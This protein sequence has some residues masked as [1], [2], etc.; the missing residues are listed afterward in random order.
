MVALY[1]PVTVS[2]VDTIAKWLLSKDSMTPKKLQKMLY[3]CYSWTLA[4]LNEN[5]DNIEVRL[6]EEKFEAWVHGPVVRNVYYK[7]RENGYN[8]IP[9]IDEEVIIDNPE[10]LDILEQ[11]YDVY[12]GYNGNELE[13]ISHQETP[14]INAREGLQPYE[15]TEREISDRDIFEYY[16]SLED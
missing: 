2:D 5:A 9:M 12:G 14:W 4:L 8:P 15:A 16:N 13:S 10:V 11:V 3:Y 7:H 1:E 6:F